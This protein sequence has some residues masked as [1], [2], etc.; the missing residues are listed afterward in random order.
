MRYYSSRS[1]IL[2]ATLLGSSFAQ[3]VAKTPAVTLETQEQKNKRV[4]AERA[5]CVATFRIACEKP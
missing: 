2:I 4:A 3:D 1:L 5:A